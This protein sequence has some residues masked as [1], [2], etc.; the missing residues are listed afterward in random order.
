MCFCNHF[1]WALSYATD[2]PQDIVDTIMKQRGV[3]KRLVEL[4]DHSTIIVQTP[5][6]RTVGNLLTGN[7][8]QTQMVISCGVLSHFTKLFAHPKKAIRKEV[9]WAISNITAGTKNQIQ[10]VIDAEIFPKLLIMLSPACEEAPEVKKEMYYICTNALAEGD[11]DQMQYLID[12]GVIQQLCG[13]LLNMD[14]K[15]LSILLEGLDSILK[16]GES[17]DT[18]GQ[19][20]EIIENCGGVEHIKALKHHKNEDVSEVASHILELIGW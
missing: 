8:D 17:S 18:L 2:G 16:Y 20:T 11:N 3:V 14:T 7:E 9:M 13:G 4:L 5:A 10:A 12:Q 19:I 1:S 6:L 15:I